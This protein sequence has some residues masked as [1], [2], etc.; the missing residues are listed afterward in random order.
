MLGG[1]T[2]SM[3]ARSRGVS[4]LPSRRAITLSWWGATSW[5][6][7][8]RTRLLIRMHARRRSL[9]RCA[10]DGGC[11]MWAGRPNGAVVL[12]GEPAGVAE[13]TAGAAGETG[14]TVVRTL[15]GAVVRV[16]GG[17]GSFRST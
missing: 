3:A 2:H 14:V 12:A 8:N 10:S 4:S 7:S 1:L 13:T 15:V 11:T 16:L 9:A 6:L 17:M 5:V